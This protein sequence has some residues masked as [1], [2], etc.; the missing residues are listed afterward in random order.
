MF[1]TLEIS[2][3]AAYCEASYAQSPEQRLSI[4]QKFNQC[5]YLDMYSDS[6]TAVFQTW[7]NH[8]VVA[9]RGTSEANDII[10]DIH[11]LLGTEN[12]TPRY[13]KHYA[14]LLRLLNGSWNGIYITGHSLGGSLAGALIESSLGHRIKG[15]RTFNEGTGLF[16]EKKTSLKHKYIAYLI[17]GD[18]IS[19][20]KKQ[21]KIA[22]VI[23]LAPKSQNRHGITEFGS[24]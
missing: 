1:R 19:E 21:S 15:C 17:D 5:T 10:S 23:V 14:L 20:L 16:H 18:W 11:V 12:A 13:H 7:D 22:K 9:L 8:V 3:W 6:E 24:V 2:R 4:A